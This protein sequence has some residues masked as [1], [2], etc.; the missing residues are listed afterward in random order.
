MIG[1]GGRKKNDETH[2]HK[3]TEDENV[4]TTTSTISVAAASVKSKPIV[5]TLLTK[6]TATSSAFLAASNNNQNIC[7]SS[8]AAAAAANVFPA[9]V[10]TAKPSAVIVSSAT[11]TA[12]QMPKL[13]DK[14][15][16]SINSNTPSSSNNNSNSN[17]REHV[18]LRSGSGLGV[19]G[20]HRGQLPPEK[21]QVAIKQ[22]QKQ[23]YHHQEHKVIRNE[24][25]RF[26]NVNVKPSSSNLTKRNTNGGNLVDHYGTS[27]SSSLDEILLPFTII[28]EPDSNLD[29]EEKM[30]MIHNNYID[31]DFGDEFGD[32]VGGVR[33]EDLMYKCEHC[34]RTFQHIQTLQAHRQMHAG[35]TQ[36]TICNKVF[37]NIGNRNAHIRMHHSLQE[38]A[39]P[40]Q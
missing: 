13:I 30:M 27:S 20:L 12:S 34:P 36:C 38:G 33:E 2:Q 23:S 32:D 21:R 17:I 37:S 10:I 35:K 26:N 9:S 11:A 3:T 39:P 1:T 22:P 14:K 40:N 19:S 28:S 24:I 16:L 6:P 25:D 18:Q 7:T 5:K 8:S 4:T 15:R 29:D 31:D